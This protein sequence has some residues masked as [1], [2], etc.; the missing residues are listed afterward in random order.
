MASYQRTLDRYVI[1]RIGGIRLQNL[2]A[3]DLDQLYA[4]LLL[5]GRA[6]GGPLKPL[7]VRYVHVLMVSAL[8]DAERKGIVVRSVARAATP[9][10][11]ATARREMRT[12]SAE[13]LRRFLN[14]IREERWFALFRVLA[15]TGLRR[16]ELCGLRWIDVDLD[17]CRLAVRQSRTTKSYEVII[18]E[19]KTSRG[20]RAI[21]LDPE[22]VSALR[23]WKT[24]QTRERLLAGPRW[25]NDLGLV[26]TVENGQPIHPNT[27]GKVFDTRAKRAGVTKIRLHDLRHTHATLLLAAGANPRVVSERLGHSSVAFTLDTYAHAMPGQQA[28][29]AAAVARLVDGTP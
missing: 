24:L 26:F 11:G 29:A 23:A 15:M 20:R 22:T 19:P 28:D 2:T 9:P 3:L 5:R 7:T 12:W 8:G 14:S 17:E 13:E 10:S 16:S 21:D 6:D 4:E 27:I 18:D 25:H 1:A